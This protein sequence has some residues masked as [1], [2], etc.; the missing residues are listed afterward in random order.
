MSYYLFIPEI[1]RSVISMLN[2]IHEI[3]TLMGISYKNDYSN[4]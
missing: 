1:A 4:M 2:Y 3:T